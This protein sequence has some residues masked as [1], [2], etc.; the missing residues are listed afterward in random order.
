MKGD[1]VDIRVIGGTFALAIPLLAIAS[2]VAQ[3]LGVLLV[4]CAVVAVNLL[5]FIDRWVRMN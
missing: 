3:S 4:M 2:D 5:Y 1:A